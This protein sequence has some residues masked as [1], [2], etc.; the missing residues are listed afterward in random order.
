MFTLAGRMGLPSISLN[1]VVHDEA[2][3]IGDCL[4][5]V[6][7]HVDEMIVVDQGSTDGTPELA[8]DLG[9][10]VVRDFCHGFADP[11]RP[12]AERS[13]SC[14]WI[15]SIDADETCTGHLLHLLPELT[16]RSLD[17]FELER[18][19]W[20]GG[21]F[22]STDWHMR[23]WRRGTAVWPVFD[24]PHRRWWVPLAA[25]VFGALEHR[26]SWVEQ[27]ADD[28]GYER[29]GSGVGAF[30]ALARAGN[31]SGAELDAMPVEQ[32]V[33]LGF[34]CAAVREGRVAA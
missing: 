9:A 12:L 29:L 1:V 23:L 30:L 5:H 3:R 26:K 10:K 2:A 33:A 16:S 6:M 34:D 11:S 4:S 28:E 31:V 27:L 22:W 18:S 8:A 14:D 25:S 20:F 19:N 17:G 24:R 32:A 21:Q 13:S 7:R 15:L